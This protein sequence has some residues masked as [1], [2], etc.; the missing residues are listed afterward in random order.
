[1]TLQR[2][3]RRLLTTLIHF[4]ELIFFYAVIYWVLHD[5]FGAAIYGLPSGVTPTAVPALQLSFATMTTIGYGTYAPDSVP[6]LITAIIQ[7]LTGL[8]LIGGFVAQMATLLKTAAAG[9]EGSA[10]LHT[11]LP[12]HSVVSCAEVSYLE[13]QLRRW[14]PPF[15]TLLAVFLIWCISTRVTGNC[16]GGTGLPT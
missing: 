9:K 15:L 8:V 11:P 7:S 3:Q 5:S 6:T 1:M 14:L 16:L 4:A 12:E 10:P 13:Y 2:A